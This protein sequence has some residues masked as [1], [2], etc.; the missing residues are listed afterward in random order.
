MFPEVVI[1]VILEDLALVHLLQ[2]NQ[3][4]PGAL[5]LLQLFCGVST[6]LHILDHLIPRIQILTVLIIRPLDTVSLHSVFD[7]AVVQLRHRLTLGAQ[8]IV[9][10]AAKLDV[11]GHPVILVKGALQSVVIISVVDSYDAFL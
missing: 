1:E 4:P 2:L 5:H 6:R 7:C 8:S 9:L 3:R 11:L 10:L